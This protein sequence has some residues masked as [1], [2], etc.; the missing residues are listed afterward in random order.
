MACKRLITSQKHRI[1]VTFHIKI[2][3]NHCEVS[4]EVNSSLDLIGYSSVSTSSCYHARLISAHKDVGVMRSLSSL[5]RAGDFDRLIMRPTAL[6][7][8]L[9]PRPDACFMT[10]ERLIRRSLT[11]NMHRNIL[12]LIPSCP[13]IPFLNRTR[14]SKNSVL[15][16]KSQNINN[17]S[18]G[19]GQTI[20]E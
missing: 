9:R 10:L 14:I 5:N 13:L 2:R 7:G 18:L 12:D 17:I 3:G 1:I 20:I 11:G 6:E 4:A 16:L 19:I 15:I 8:R